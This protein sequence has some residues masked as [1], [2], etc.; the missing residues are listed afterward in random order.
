MYAENAEEG[1]QDPAQAVVQRTGVKAQISLA[2]HGRNQEQVDQPADTQQAQGEKPDRAGNR[3]AVIKA[4]RP[5][6]AENPQQVTDH[7]AVRVV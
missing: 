3:L 6:E 7:L 1:Q 2:I 4:V 5:G